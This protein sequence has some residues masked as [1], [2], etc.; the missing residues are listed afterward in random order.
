VLT[1]GGT[2]RVL[3]TAANAGA[4]LVSLFGTGQT[5]LE[6]TTG[7]TASLNPADRNLAVQLDAAGTLN[8]MSPLAVAVTGSDGDDVFAATA[9][10]L[11]AA[12]GLDGSGGGNTL[13]L[14]GGGRFNL[15]APSRLSNIQTVTA[16]EGLGAALPVVVLRDGLDVTLDV[17]SGS[18]DAVVLGAANADVINLGNG[19]DWVFGTGADETV[20]GGT[21]GQALVYLTAATMGAIVTGNGGVMNLLVQGGGTEM[22]GDSLT[23]ISSVRLLTA[24]NDFTANGQAGLTVIASSGTDRITVGDGSQ[25]VL[26]TGGNTAVVAS[27]ANAGVAIQAAAD[28]GTTTLEITG[29][30]TATLNAVDSG[31]TVRL[32]TAEVLNLGMFGFMTAIGT[33]GEDL[34]QAGA[35]NQTL[36]TGGGAGDVLAGFAGFGD[37]FKGSSSELNGVTIRNFGGNEGIDITDLL[38]GPA[39]YQFNNGTITVTDGTHTAAI[40]LEGSFNAGGFHLDPDTLLGTVVTYR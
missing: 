18:G 10:A 1:A 32:D 17:Q 24:G 12:L 2:T 4:A 34:I 8:L 21:A 26:T 14:D 15:A 35:A 37:T 13:A 25:R 16:T 11:V 23:G 20:N 40:T 22:M 3:A 33:G 6:I 36:M 27:A 38:P 19:T 7:G 28:G 31:L 29:A 5:T 39:N 9:S 30:G